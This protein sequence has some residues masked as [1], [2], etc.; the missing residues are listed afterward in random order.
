MKARQELSLIVP[1]PLPPPCLDS[2]SSRSHRSH[3]KL[4][5]RSEIRDTLTAGDTQEP[6]NLSPPGL[7]VAP[8][9][10]LLRPKPGRHPTPSP[11][12]AQGWAALEPHCCLHSHRH[13]LMHLHLAP[14]ELPLMKNTNQKHLREL[15]WDPMGWC[16]ICPGEGALQGRGSSPCGRLSEATQK[17]CV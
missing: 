11:R 3:H 10:H 5:G 14:H 2:G 8:T 15:G 9:F 1:V 6:L 13:L 7:R 12:C 16:G 17:H 4:R